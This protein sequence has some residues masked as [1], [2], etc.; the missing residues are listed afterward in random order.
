MI[1]DARDPYEEQMAQMP[2][3]GNPPPVAK[4][5]LWMA[6]VDADGDTFNAVVFDSELEALRY[7]VAEHWQVMQVELGRSLL[8][9]ARA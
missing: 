8:E 4:L 7:A 3:P 9:Q 2:P 6:Y 1:A 5:I